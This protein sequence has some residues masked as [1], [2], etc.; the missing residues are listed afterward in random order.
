MRKSQPSTGVRPLRAG[1]VVAATAVTAVA[2]LAAPA[3][4]TDV[5]VTITPAQAITGT[6][7]TFAGTNVLSGITAPGGRFVLSTATC[8]TAYN[9]ANGGTA[10]VT[11]V[12]TDANGG[13]VVVP[14]LAAGAYKLCLYADA[15]S[16]AIAGHS[17]SSLTTVA[18]GTIPSPGSN[19]GGAQTFTSTGA[20][21]SVTGTIGVTFTKDAT[22]CPD[23]YTPTST[24]ATVISGTAVKAGSNAATVTV[25]NTLVVGTNYLTCLYN[26]STA[27]SSTL[28]ARATANYSVMPPITISPKNGPAGGGYSMTVAAATAN[29]ITSSTPGVTYTTGNCTALYTDGGGSADPWAGVV[30]KISNSKVAV[31]V[32]AGVT[33]TDPTATYNVCLYN[34]VSGSSALL[35]APGVLTIAPALAYGTMTVSVNGA[36]GG[37]LPGSGPA[38][39]GTLVAF[40]GITGLPSQAA[41]VA[42]ATLSATLGTSP[43]TGLEVTATDEITGYTTPHAAGNEKLTVTTSA[44]SVT[45]TGNAFTFSYGVTSTPSTAAGTATT[46]TLDILGSGFGSLT[47]AAGAEADATHTPGGAPGVGVYLV[48]NGW[49]AAAEGADKVWTT[50][51][52]TQCTGVTKISDTELICTLDLTKSFDGTYHYVPGTVP[53]GV[54]D[55]AVVNDASLTTTLAVDTN[56]SR[57]SS[58]SVFTV[59]SY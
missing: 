41:V 21:T 32:P 34:G 58:G 8:P 40:K 22:S 4:A 3:Y 5:A 46:V 53:D 11:L 14:A 36:T 27:A 54:Y 44:G 30:T 55:V 23:K 28:L 29:S 6:V 35:G 52:I 59:A 2:G 45:T 49:Y 33:T 42:G 47:Y 31:A 15:T 39:G 48:N 51:L 20:F 56:I 26:G 17:S 1:L 25:P 19:A 16:G 43:I 7:V 10:A 37:S 18:S 12:K 13:T 50:G 38:Q 9:G 57:V 24:T